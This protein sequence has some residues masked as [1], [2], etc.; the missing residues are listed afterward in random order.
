MLGAIHC[1][2][3]NSE[4]YRFGQLWADVKRGNE[5]SAILFRYKFKAMT[6]RFFL[7]IRLELVK[8]V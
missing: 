1:R 5:E 7:S 6:V 8:V 4:K 3:F 2:H